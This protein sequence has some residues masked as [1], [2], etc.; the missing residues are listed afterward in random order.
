MARWQDS[1][2]ESAAGNPGR[3]SGQ[4]G[5]DVHI[6]ELLPEEPT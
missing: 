1:K 3:R 4:M 5:Y 2:E 6:T